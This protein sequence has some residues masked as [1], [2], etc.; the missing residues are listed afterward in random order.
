MNAPAVF[1][2]KDGTLVEN[3]PYNVDPARIRLAPGALEAV[4]RLHR[5][6]FRIAVVTN[7]AGV[8]LGKFDERA[9]GVVEQRLRDLLAEAGV[10]LLGMYW[11]P[12]HPAGAVA[13]YALDCACR[14]PNPGL[15]WKAARDHHIDLERSWMVGDILDDIEAGR[16]AGCRAL[17]LDV[18]HETEW[19]LSRLRLPHL[20]APGLARAA[21]AIVDTDRAVHIREEPASC[22]SPTEVHHANQ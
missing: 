6:G 16:R 20:V 3:L 8:A 18:G 17:L 4:N 2:D 15:L 1:L 12:H 11:C 22:N 5:H 14:K 9:L 19:R 7:Q 13:R 21:A 10:P